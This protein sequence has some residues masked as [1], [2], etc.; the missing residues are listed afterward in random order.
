MSKTFYDEKMTEL[1]FFFLKEMKKKDWINAGEDFLGVH[2]LRQQA[3]GTARHSSPRQY[4]AVH[5]S[6]PLGTTW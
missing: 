2:D 1:R 3:V 5:S 6:V 4:P